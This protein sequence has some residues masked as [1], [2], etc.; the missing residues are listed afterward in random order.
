M[1]KGAWDCHVH[2]I[3]PVD[4]F[5]LAPDRGY[6]PADVPVEEYVALMDR[7]G[8][9]RAVLVQPSIYGTDNRAMVDALVRYP[10]RFRGVAV[11]DGHID[12]AGLDALHACGVRG[13]RANLLNPGGISLD[14]AIALAPRLAARAWHLQVQIDVSSFDAWNV[15]LGLP[16]PVVV[17]HL[18]C[19]AASK[20]PGTPGFRTLIGH[21]RAGRCYVKLS[22]AYRVTEWTATRYADATALARALVRANPRQLVWGSDWPHTDVRRD[23]PNDG[24]LLNLLAE[25]I[26][27][28]GLRR[29]VLVDTPDALYGA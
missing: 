10:T 24:D 3:G 13:V 4:R 8:I 1:P 22:G 5:P 11:V 15:L 2:A 16:L 25:W 6:T 17:D 9:A 12:D 20:G 19:M 27:D 29:A 28:A 14:D 21:V 23:M 26:P 7:L 18:G